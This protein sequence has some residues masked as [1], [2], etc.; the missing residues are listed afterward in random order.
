MAI[1][2]EMITFAELVKPKFC[3]F[4]PEKRLELTTEGGLD[5]ISQKSKI[6]ESC[7][8]LRAMKIRV[9]L[10]IEPKINGKH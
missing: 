8:R 4:V 1:T 2:D 3:C 6:K 7:D 9:S 5:V 10:F